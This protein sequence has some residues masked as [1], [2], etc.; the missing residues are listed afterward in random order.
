MAL[1][2]GAFGLGFFESAR[3]LRDILMLA[4]VTL[5]T[6]AVATFLALRHFVTQPLRAITAQLEKKSK[7]GPFLARASAKESRSREL[8]ELVTAYNAT[9]ATITSMQVAEIETSFQMK[10]MEGELLLK[11]ELE[12]RNQQIEQA[13]AKLE[14]RVREMTL[15]LDVAHQLGSTL[16]LSEILKAVTQLVGISMGVD[17]FTAMLVEPDGTLK[18]AGSFGLDVERCASFQLKLGEGASGIAAQTREP[19]YITD[20]QSDPRY[21]RGPDD[22][23]GPASLLSVPMICRDQFVGILNFTRL[24]K[25]AFGDSD[26]VLL[27]LMASQ[28]ALA[29]LNAQLFTRMRELNPIDPITG[30]LGPRHVAERLNVELLRAQRLALPLSLIRIEVDPYSARAAEEKGPAADDEIL[31]RIAELIRKKVRATDVVA[32]SGSEEFLLVLP[33]CGQR[34]AQTI[35]EMFRRKVE[36]IGEAERDTTDNQMPRVTISAGVATY[37]ED[38]TGLERILEAA[39]TALRKAKAAGRNRTALFQMDGVD[40]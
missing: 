23:D 12:N 15:L 7:V 33:D 27:Q 35:A 9:L 28:A 26:I 31:R 24:R 21:I 13:N 34:E 30:C 36:Q 14:Q 22:P 18:I 32:R 16:E 11:T 2:V 25:D 6:V 10:Q 40:S 5:I 29:V 19:V 17:Q 37:P 38:A 3:G 8:A 4:G 1:V 39:D 20:L